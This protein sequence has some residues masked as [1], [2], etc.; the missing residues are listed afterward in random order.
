M[1]NI[2]MLS[3]WRRIQFVVWDRIWVH[4]LYNNWSVKSFGGRLLSVFVPCVFVWGCF[5]FVLFFCFLLHLCSSQILAMYIMGS[6]EGTLFKNYCQV[7]TPWGVQSY[8]FDSACGYH[9]YRICN[10]NH[11]VLWT[12]LAVFR[13]NWHRWARW[14]HMYPWNMP[15][16]QGPSQPDDASLS[17]CVRNWTSGSPWMGGQFTKVWYQVGHHIFLLVLEVVPW[18]QQFVL[19]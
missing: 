19:V 2:G 8:G 18:L 5:F 3:M 12:H 7:S 6:R 16:M 15:C 1:W 10:L 13:N 17:V 11:C 14:H 4:C 9:Y